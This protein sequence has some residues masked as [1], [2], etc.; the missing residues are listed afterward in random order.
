M[1]TVGA[2]MREW[3]AMPNATETPNVKATKKSPL[4]TTCRGTMILNISELHTVQD[5]TL[6][7]ELCFSKAGV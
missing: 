1:K 4:Y 6:C 2:L 5:Y 3:S 7:H